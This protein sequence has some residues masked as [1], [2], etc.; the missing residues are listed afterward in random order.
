MTIAV[1]AYTYSTIS[2]LQAYG[3]DLTVYDA[4]W[5]DLYTLTE[6]LMMAEVQNAVPWATWTLPSFDPDLSNV[7]VVDIT[8]PSYTKLDKP[9]KS[10]L[11]AYDNFLNLGRTT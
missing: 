10:F 4:H 11:I 6:I 9:H 5:W 8:A 1:N 2:R 3:V 7:G